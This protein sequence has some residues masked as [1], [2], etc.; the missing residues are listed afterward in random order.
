MML[1]IIQPSPASRYF[2]PLSEELT[3]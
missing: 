3:N 2:L 1:L